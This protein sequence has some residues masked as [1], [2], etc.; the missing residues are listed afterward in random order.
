MIQKLLIELRFLLRLPA[1]HKNV[2]VLTAAQAFMMSLNSLNVFAGGL[3]GS[4]LAPS[5]KLATLPVATII[6][7]TALASI[8]IT[9]AMKRFGRRQTFLFVAA[10][11]FFVSLLAAYAITVAHFY[12]FSLSTLLLGVTSACI[13]QFRFASMESV[14]E[15]QMPKAAS[16]VLLGGIIAAFLGPETALIGKDFFE[17]E[18][19][20]SFLLLGGLFVAGFLVL[21]GYENKLPESASSTIEARPL[22]EIAKNKVFW[23]AILGATIGYAVMSFVMT[24][25]PVSMHVMDGHSLEATK[26][27]IQSHIVAMFLPS[28]FTGGL[29]KRFGVLKIMVSGLI[30]YLICMALGYAG[31]FV[32]N[33]WLALVLLGIG[34]NFLFVAGTSLLPQTHTSGE[35]FKVQA[36]NEFFLFT[37][38]AIASLSAGWI[39]FEFGWETLLLITIPFILIQFAALW[40]WKKK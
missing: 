6:V 5:E 15:E 22:K 39:V 32:H 28:L 4:Q 12:L 37:S 26:R 36:F 27:V 7:G 23:V 11:S 3:I 16:Y 35:R 25:T 1:M 40:R 13:M 38:Q 31:H 29:I 33:Y 20:G 24:A 30:A 21:M 14:A 8:P 19:A 9:I 17:A 18:F 10:Y 2:W 34:W